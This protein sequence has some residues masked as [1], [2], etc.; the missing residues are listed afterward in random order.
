MQIITPKASPIKNAFSSL[1]EQN[2]Q[3]LSRKIMNI[4]DNTP[5]LMRAIADLES[6]QIWE[7]IPHLKEVKNTFQGTPLGLLFVRLEDLCSKH[8][9]LQNV[10]NEKKNKER[11]AH[12]T[13][14]K[15]STGSSQIRSSKAISIKDIILPSPEQNELSQ[16]I[17]DLWDNTP[18]IMGAIADLQ[19]DQISQMIPLLRKVKNTLQGTPLE[20]LFS[21]LE[22]LCT[23]R[24]KLREIQNAERNMDLKAQEPDNLPQQIIDILN[25]TP[26]IMKVIADL[27]S[28]QISQMI[29]LLKKVSNI[30][31]ETPLEL[32][33]T[34]QYSP[35]LSQI[36]FSKANPT[37]NTSSPKQDDLSQQ[38]IKILNT[39]PEIMY[40]I[41]DLKSDQIE[42]M[43]THLH[44]MNYTFQG[45]PLESLF[46]PL[47]HKEM[48]EMSK[49]KKNTDKSVQDNSSQIP[50]MISYKTKIKYI[51][52]PNINPYPISNEQGNQGYQDLAESREAAAAY[53]HATEESMQNLQRLRN[54]AK[55][56][57]KQVDQELIESVQMLQ[58][59]MQEAHTA[60]SRDL[61]DTIDTMH[62]EVQRVITNMN[63]SLDELQEAIQSKMK[64]LNTELEEE[65]NSYKKNL[66]QFIIDN[67]NELEELVLQ[68]K[69][70][71]WQHFNAEK[72]K[73]GSQLE[74]GRAQMDQELEKAASTVNLQLR[75]LHKEIELARKE[76][77]NIKQ[78]VDAEVKENIGKATTGAKRLAIDALSPAKVGD[79]AAEIN[80]ARQELHHQIEREIQDAVRKLKKEIQ[81]TLAGSKNAKDPEYMDQEDTPGDA[82]VRKKQQHDTVTNNDEESSKP[83]E[84]ADYSPKQT[85]NNVDHLDSDE[86]LDDDLYGSDISDEDDE[87][88]T[89]GD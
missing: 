76:M 48:Q 73:L 59:Q 61:Q 24:E 10:K 19:S 35:D 21:S 75:D 36:T 50:T 54:D 89:E 88:Y 83:E 20:L 58:K 45:T 25:N 86:N 18:E 3:E 23:Q 9:K 81:S 14:I 56:Y 1:P 53:K 39:Y 65:K 80:K 70:D 5:K 79:T 4:L 43:I 77:Q 8:E 41:L 22:K 85:S 60:T 17:I 64:V 27:K 15:A 38:I 87:D 52:A 16:Q 72:S 40:A 51:N 33:S 67:R 47:E 32:L 12:G 78:N 84:E 30:L 74:H 42:H 57:Q 62:A 71:F 63:R 34:L 29:P 11:S 69:Q 66:N 28:D 31:Q 6:D 55:A 82:A 26:K 13:A 7:M 44:A 46:A 2:E 49:A 37:N 68:T